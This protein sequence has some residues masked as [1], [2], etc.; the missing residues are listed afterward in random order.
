MLG[1]SNQDGNISGLSKEEE[2]SR[3]IVALNYL[4]NAFGEVIELEK[5]K[6]LE[7]LKEDF[8][9]S[10]FHGFLT[11]YKDYLKNLSA[12]TYMRTSEK[13]TR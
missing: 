3:V 6:L 1:N 12:D 10:H 5:K 2:L 9:N 8:I 11:R 13:Q 4:S 7:K